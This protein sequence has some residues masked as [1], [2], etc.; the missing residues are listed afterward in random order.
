MARDFLSLI[1]LVLQHIMFPLQILVFLH[2]YR[3]KPDN[4]E[5][6]FMSVVCTN[7]ESVHATYTNKLLP[8]NDKGI[9][10]SMEEYVPMTGKYTMHE[11]QIFVV[12]FWLK[13]RL[14]NWHKSQ[15]KRMCTYKYYC[16]FTCMYT[17]LKST[18]PWPC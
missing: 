2:L 13:M 8:N 10:L 4:C 9:Q 18:H 6:R 15:Q 3:F 16:A 14:P 7:M 17:Q 1:K 12:V 5:Y 11:I